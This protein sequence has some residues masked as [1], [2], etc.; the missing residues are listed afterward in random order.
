MR[1]CENCPIR[2]YYAKCFDIHF[3]LCDC[4]YECEYAKER[5]KGEEERSE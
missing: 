2:E 3:D 5:E 1:T 4:P